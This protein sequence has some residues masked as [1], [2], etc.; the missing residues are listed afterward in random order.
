VF[1]IQHLTYYRIKAKAIA[2]VFYNYQN[3]KCQ[4]SNDLPIYLHDAYAGP[5]LQTIV[6]NHTQPN[7]A[8]VSIDLYSN[9]YYSN[10]YYSKNMS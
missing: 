4:M 3:E 8:K 9:V 7:L 6:F 5:P 2:F 10:V 1:E